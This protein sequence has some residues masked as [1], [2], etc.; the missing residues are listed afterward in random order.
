MYLGAPISQNFEL[1]ENRPSLREHNPGRKRISH[2]QSGHLGMAVI[3]IEIENGECYYEYCT[4]ASQYS[5]GR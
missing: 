4:D 2:F 1:S 5:L 3:E